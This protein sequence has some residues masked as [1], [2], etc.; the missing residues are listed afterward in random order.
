MIED[1]YVYG[2][3]SYRATV[4][5]DDGGDITQYAAIDENDLHLQYSGHIRELTANELTAND[6]RQVKATHCHYCKVQDIVSG[7]RIKDPDDREFDV[8]TVDN[9][10]QLNKFLKIQLDYRAES[11]EWQKSNGKD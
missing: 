11:V 5:V 4:T 1:I 3:R 2:F 7:D 10:H 6:K 8:A 9:P